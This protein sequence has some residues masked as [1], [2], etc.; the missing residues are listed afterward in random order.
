MFSNDG[1]FFLSGLEVTN[2]MRLPLQRRRPCRRTGQIAAFQVSVVALVLL[3]AAWLGAA[4]APC[5]PPVLFFI[6]W[7][8]STYFG[9]PVPRIGRLVPAAAASDIG[10]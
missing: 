9:L 8:R 3:V 5:P 10:T 4:F 1:Q 2:S 6:W 7:Q